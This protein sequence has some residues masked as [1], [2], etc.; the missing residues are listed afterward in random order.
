MPST[1][2]QA[3]DP[4]DDREIIGGY[5][6][7]VATLIRSLIRV[8]GFPVSHQDKLYAYI[9]ALKKTTDPE[10][11][12][13]L[14]KL[15]E[16]LCS[17][18]VAEIDPQKGIKD[19]E[20]ELRRIVG[21]LGESISGMAQVNADA[22][23]SLDTQLTDLRQAVVEDGEPVQFSKKIEAIANSISETTTVL[24]NEI[25]QSRSQV[26]DAGKKIKTLEKELHQTRA[27]ML[28]DGL[29]GLF[30]RRSFAQFIGQALS[31]FDPQN[32][33]CLIVLD[34]DRFKRINDTYGHVIGDALLIKLSRTLKEQVQEPAYLARY[35]GE[36]FAIMLAC[37]LDEAARFC[38]DLLNTIR[39]SRWL[40]RSQTREITI[41]ATLSAGVAMQVTKDTPESLIARADKAM[42]LAK[43]RGR[44]RLHT[45]RD[46][47]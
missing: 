28:S 44:D 8:P 35:G 19:Q 18:V 24:K 37:S 20:N 47:E 14:S 36:E 9:S 17:T 6:E 22:G 11:L 43:E 34:V 2:K 33:W 46:L 39:N 26:K 21:L 15:I 41:S 38:E 42:Y 27:E 45:E 40:Y 10:D 4:P 13:E 12:S 30:N 3:T 25:K 23:N 32:P 31:S 7:I 5:Q 1:E 29:T 16:N